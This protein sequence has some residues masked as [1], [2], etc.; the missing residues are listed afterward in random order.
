MSITGLLIRLGEIAFFTKETPVIACIC[1]EDLSINIPHSLDHLLD[2]EV[3][4]WCSVIE[5]LNLELFHLVMP[6]A[7]YTI[8]IA[9]NYRKYDISQLLLSHSSWNKAVITLLKYKCLLKLQYFLPV[10]WHSTALDNMVDL[11]E[12]SF[13]M[14]AKEQ[15]HSESRL[16]DKGLH[17]LVRLCLYTQ[18]L[19]S[20]L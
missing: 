5:P 3:L 8:L 19:L 14:N 4:E 16:V 11:Q 20:T 10:I 18:T 13:T 1:L 2:V 6:L 17:P 15:P 7:N 12:V 9:N